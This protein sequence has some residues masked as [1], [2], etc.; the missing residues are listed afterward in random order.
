MR[1]FFY[2]GASKSAIITN[3]ILEEIQWET[4]SSE[5]AQELISE[6]IWDCVKNKCETLEV[7]T[8]DGEDGI[9][10][11]EAVYAG[12]QDDDSMS[13]TKTVYSA[14]FNNEKWELWAELQKEFK[15]QKGRGSEE[16]SEDLCT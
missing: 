14:H 12:L 9:W 6:K 10:Y 11:V 2:V 5:A 7:Q 13:A 16:F 1:D 15:C 4:L 8:L 3:G